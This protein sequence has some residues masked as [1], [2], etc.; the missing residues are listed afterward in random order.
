MTEESCS[1]EVESYIKNAGQHDC[2][3]VFFI[4]SDD[5]P[6]HQH[7]KFFERK[8]EVVTQDLRYSTARKVCCFLVE[9]VQL[10][11]FIQVVHDRKVKTLENIFLKTNVKMGGLNYLLSEPP[12]QYKTGSIE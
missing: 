8:Y 11:E 6:A 3:F 2:R 4:T 12:V 5:I 1:D 10:S 9:F 7:M